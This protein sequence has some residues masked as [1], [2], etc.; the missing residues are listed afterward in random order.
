MLLLDGKL[1]ND[2]IPLVEC[3]G[4]MSSENRTNLAIIF[5]RKPSE[6]ME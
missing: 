3:S 4:V 5:S 6:K 1:E 2:V